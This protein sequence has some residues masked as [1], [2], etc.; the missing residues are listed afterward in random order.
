MVSK[1]FRSYV[2]DVSSVQQNLLPFGL[3]GNR[4]YYKSSVKTLMMMM[5]T[6]M[7]MMMMMM[8]II[9]IIII[10]QVHFNIYT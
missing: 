2:A 6:I 10:T 7:M 5:M 4:A 1:T 9:I 8:I 3:N